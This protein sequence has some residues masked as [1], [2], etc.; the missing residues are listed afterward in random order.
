[1][2]CELSKIRLIGC[3]IGKVKRRMRKILANFVRHGIENTMRDIKY[4][5]INRKFFIEFPDDYYHGTSV[6]DSSIAKNYQQ[7]VGLALQKDDLFQ[8]F[9]LLPAI[10]QVID[11]VTLGQGLLY[12]DRI[13]KETV[14]TQEFIKVL[15]HIDQN[16]AQ[17]YRFRSGF[18]S[19]L[20]LR[21]LN[22]YIDLQNNF[23][24]M[25]NFQIFE[26]GGGFG[27]LASLINLLDAPAC[28][29]LYDLPNLL[30]LQKKFLNSLG[31]DDNCVFR[32]GSDPARIDTSAGRIDLVISNYAFSELSKQ[33]Q[34]SYLE[35]IILK[36]QRGFIIWNDVG[37]R[38]MGAL[39]L[40]DLV[41]I[42]PNSQIAPDKPSF[43]SSNNILI[44][45]SS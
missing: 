1:M 5:C 17:K 40:A 9:R 25:K 21:Y 24:S 14:F 38:L 19:P 36:A 7:T 15:T 41:R 44:W 45:G 32:D 42:I 34:E 12:H 4:S 13:V 31:V 30:E 27:G 18:F 22:T 37:E 39:S 29:T 33:V 35:E 23:G 20:G 8:N 28:Y 10:K 3:T 2:S 43:A 26:I 11:T 6:S 16:G